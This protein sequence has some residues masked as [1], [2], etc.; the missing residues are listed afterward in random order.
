M[1][2]RGG[3]GLPGEGRAPGPPRGRGS[4]MAQKIVPNLWFDTQAEEAAQ[5]Y[6]D[7]LGNGRVISVAR[8]PEGAPGPA[9][10]VMS[11]E[12][13]VAGM[14]LVGINGGPQFGLRKGESRQVNRAD[15]AEGER[16]RD[17]L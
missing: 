8:Y 12:F 11:V 4:G 17:R 7:V 14:R 1:S 6:I 9:G 5:Y 16:L 10:Q 3:G 2:L 13:E 15:Q